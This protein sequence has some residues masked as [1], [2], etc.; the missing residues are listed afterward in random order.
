[1]GGEEFLVVLTGTDSTERLEELR[2]RVESYPW[3][4]LARNLHVTVSI[5]ATRLRP[6]RATQAALLGEADRH[7]YAAKSAGRNRVVIGTA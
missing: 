3:E 2:R 7:L 6:G 5:G 4:R 1:M